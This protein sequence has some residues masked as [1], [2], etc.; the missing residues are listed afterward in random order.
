MA[1]ADD[2]AGEGSGRPPRLVAATSDRVLERDDLDDRLVEFLAAG[3]PAVWLRTRALDDRAFHD[4]AVRVR[5]RCAEHG[6]ETWIGD[7]ADVARLVGADVLQLPEAGLSVAGARRGVGMGM[8]IGRSVHSVEAARRGIAR[9]VDHL[10]VGTMYATASHPDKV[11][12]GPRLLVEVNEAA[13]GLPLYAIGGIT[14]SRV[15][16]L[17]RSGAYGV[18]TIGG[19]WDADNPSTA[20]RA[21]LEVLEAT[22]GPALH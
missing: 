17:L 2:R 15:E 20:V 1:L 21:F 12:E 19:L 8:R 18:A 14:P 13:P 10:V 11:P 3:L 16:P 22:P 6:A 9:G 5:E 7:R 4:L